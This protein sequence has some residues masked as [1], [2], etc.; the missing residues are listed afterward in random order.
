MKKPTLNRMGLGLAQHML[1]AIIM[2][3]IA[4]IIFNSYVSVRSMNETKIYRVNFYGSETVFE[5]SDL[6]HNILETAV[7]DITRLVIIKAQ[8]ETNGEFDPARKIDVTEYV[9]RQGNGNACPITAVYQ[10]DDLIKWGKNGVEYSMRPWSFSDF[11]NYYGVATDPV[12]FALDEYGE[13]YFIGFHSS[14]VSAENSVELE[15][16]IQSGNSSENTLLHKMQEYTTEQLEDMAFSYII[17]EAPQGISLNREDDGT[18]TVYLTT[19]NCRY[20]TIDGEKQLYTYADNWIDYIKLQ[21]N[22]A[23]TIISLTE[24]YELYQNCNEIY[25]SDKSNLKYAVRMMTEEGLQTY[26]NNPALI[27]AKESDITEYFAEYRRYFIYYP[28]SLEFTGNANLTSD[29]VYEYMREYQYAY[30]ET[31]HIWI[32]VD[33]SYSVEGD[34]FSEANEVFGN[35]VPYLEL[36]VGAI[37]VLFLIWLGIGIYLTVTA[38]VMYNEAGES[39]QYLNRIDHIWTELMTL[40]AAAFVYISVL[41]FKRILLLADATYVNSSELIGMVSATDFY[42]YAVYALY[43]I[44][45]SLFLN[46]FWYSFVRRFRRANLWKGSFVYWIISKIRQGIEFV[47]SHGNIAIN[48]L[49]PYNFFI[50][51]NLVAVLAVYTVRDTSVFVFAILLALVLFDCGIGVLIF[52]NSAERTDIVEGI[53]RIRDGEVDYKLDVEA[54]HGSNRE[55]ADAVN[56][57][58]EGIRKAVRTSMKDEQMKT[59]LITNVSHDIKTPLTSII[60]Y[61][62]LLKR[63]KIKD[64]PAKSYIHILD[65]KSQRL[66][67]LTD[68]L[69]EASKISSGNIELQREPLQLAELVNQAIGE[70]SER[71]EEKHLNVIFDGQKVSE[72]IYADSRRMWRIIENLFNNICKYALESTRVYIDLAASEGRVELTIKNISE[73]RMNIQADELTERFIRGDFSRT[74]E[75]SGL[76]LSIAKSLTQVQGGN[77]VIYLDGDLFKVVLNFPEYVTENAELE[78]ADL[79]NQQKPDEKER[80]QE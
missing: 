14:N 44:L 67:Q 59:D 46:M 21:T 54:L 7:S 72:C 58:G 74:T 63:L 16:E 41:A 49:I 4:A 12:N 71:L 34:A 10:L 9:N 39:V 25:Q 75:G 5:E 53:R 22:L 31:T 32:G 57:I 70:F 28:D 77:F 52:K 78:N 27:N 1:A 33:T 17:R 36:I 38:G 64:E 29:D 23:D 26:T 80:E 62:D 61:V 37:I 60:N 43:G 18:Q 3:I 24:D 6:F 35:V 11:V 55:M 40:L 76:G 13:L 69:V 51:M 47:M 73:C 20:E 79:Q 66:K 2:M 65:A 15:N 56:N 48:T 50:L 68:D 42:K 30:P 8:M 19:I 45:V